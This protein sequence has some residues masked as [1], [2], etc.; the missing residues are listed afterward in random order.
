MASSA[1]VNAMIIVHLGFLTEFMSR[2]RFITDPL[3][4]KQF[5]LFGLTL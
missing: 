4:S 5:S 3:L 2:K 1:S